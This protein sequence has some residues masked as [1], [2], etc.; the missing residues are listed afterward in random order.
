MMESSYIGAEW[1]GKKLW[2]RRRHIIGVGVGGGGGGGG[3]R[4][5][6]D[7]EKMKKKG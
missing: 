3:D 1:I 2:A 5:E 4:E 6:L 7:R